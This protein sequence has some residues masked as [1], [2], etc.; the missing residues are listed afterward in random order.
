MQ[1]PRC[2]ATRCGRG[3]AA[4]APACAP[5]AGPGHQSGMPHGCGAG[6]AYSAITVPSISFHP[7]SAF[8]GTSWN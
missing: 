4:S 2:R 5:P 8:N 3:A 7:I 6:P 1:L